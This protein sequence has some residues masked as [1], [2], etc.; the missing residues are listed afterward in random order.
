MKIKNPLK[1]LIVLILLIFA[2]LESISSN[3]YAKQVDFSVEYLIEIVYNYYSNKGNND[4][5]PNDD[6]LKGY[7]GDELRNN[8]T[9][10]INAQWRI[11]SQGML[12]I[13]QDTYNTTQGT[14]TEKNKAGLISALSMV[15]QFKPL[16]NNIIE[17]SSSK[18]AEDIGDISPEPVNNEI[19]NAGSNNEKETNA[20][21]DIGVAIDT[22]LGIGGRIIDGLAGIIL[23]V[24]KII[25]MVVG[26]LLLRII[27][28]V[29]NGVDG[30]VNG[31]P[32][33]LI[34]FNKIP[35][36][37]INFWE[38]VDSSL[39]NALIINNIRAQVSIWYVAIRNL[40]ATILAIMVLYVGIRM[41]ISSVAEEKAKYKRMLADWVVSLLLL[42]VLH[43]IM[44]LIININDGI[45]AILAKA[46]K[47]TTGESL[48]IMDS[49]WVKAMFSLDAISFTNQ[50]A[51][52]AL[53]F[54]LA[55]MCF[56][57]FA[58]YVKRM[59]TIAFLIMIAPIITITYSL[60]RMGDGKSQALNTWFKNFVYNILLQPFHCI[61]YLALVKTAIDEISAANLSSVVIAI[62]MVFFMYEAE[63]IIK[64]IFHFEGKSVANTIAQAALFG[65][66]I[67]LVSKVAS[68]SKAVKG[69]AGSASSPNKSQN[70][71]NT[72]NT[73]YQQTTNNNT[74]TTEGFSSTDSS[75][76]DSS[77]TTN[78]R[79]TRRTRRTSR[80][81]RQPNRKKGSI[82][83]T[84][85][86]ILK[87]A[88]IATAKGIAKLPLS[89]ALGAA[90]LGT[91]NL[92]SGITG[93]QTGWGISKNIMSN[94]AEKE[95]LHN[96]ATLYNDL[97]PI[98]TSRGY[99]NNWIR[100]HTK[101][102]LNGDVKVEDYEKD[103]YDAVLKE[104]DRYIDQGLS[105]DDSITQVEQNVAGIQGG[106]LGEATIKQ[107][108]TGKIKQVINDSRSNYNYSRYTR[109]R[110]R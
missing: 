107:R 54:M 92:S 45:V 6:P 23:Y 34:L 64:E 4:S 10:A 49:L 51:Y 100:E 50:V 20:G 77:S 48:T 65:S 86:G 85:G 28:L 99:D 62:M 60:D 94:E 79:R 53:Y 11:D 9:N 52:M 43:Y 24:F 5:L 69:Y 19:E 30:A 25:P 47:G 15:N 80:T 56:V 98:Y 32:L 38:T 1:K 17:F 95:H 36:L 33:D 41:A 39:P 55:T 35:L 71:S 44:L 31:L 18:I 91:G 105:A 57:F 101:D 40:S 37:G 104:M 3:V 110:K 73:Q 27:G 82:W 14:E 108:F 106:Y 68:T 103:Y 61:I 78:S 84:S 87:K 2:I 16:A 89:I 63:D 70:E 90:S 7:E 21:F 46:D 93:A 97:S 96:F 26:W 67:G 109:R 75:S 88:G 42:F 29:I 22:G 72:K 13:F 8:I 58:T 81:S 83:K 66:A 76:T 102:L 59:I 12:Q 74:D